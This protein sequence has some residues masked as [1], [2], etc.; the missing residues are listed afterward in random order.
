MKSITLSLFD[1]GQV[2]EAKKAN[3][4]EAIAVHKNAVVTFMGRATEITKHFIEFFG[5]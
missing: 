2:S 5:L 1:K 4:K 3:K